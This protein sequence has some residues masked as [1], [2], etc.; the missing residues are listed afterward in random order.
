[1]LGSRL[2]RVMP[3]HSRDEES[4]LE[5]FTKRVCVSCES[6]LREKLGLENR[7]SE[8]YPVTKET[9]IKI[10]VQVAYPEEDCRE[11][12]TKVM[13]AQESPCATSK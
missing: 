8:P 10:L 7:Y 6:L 5:R 3:K 2:K 13:K 11:R 1:M 4:D 12:V 9:V